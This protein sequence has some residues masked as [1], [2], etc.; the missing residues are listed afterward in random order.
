MDAPGRA[1]ILKSEAH[2][3]AHAIPLPDP[4]I[5]ALDALE[6]QGGRCRVV[7]GS[8][9]DSL[10]GLEP[11]D[12][13][14]EVYGLELRQIA[15]TLS[16]LGKTDPVGKAFAV[17]KLWTG[18]REYDFS[19]PRRESKTGA[20]HRGFE[21]EPDPSLS[22]RDAIQRRDFTLNALLYDHRANEIIDYCGGIRDL[23]ERLLRHVSPAFSED[24][25]RALRAMQLAARFKLTLD[26]D[27]A[28]MCR[29]IGP[30]F[31]TL[32]KERIW[33]EWEKWATRSRSPAHGLRAL[34]KSGWLAFFPEL[35]ALA[36]LPQDP[37][38]HP[39]GDV[40]THTLCALDALAT[41][42]NWTALPKDARAIVAFATLCH[43]LGKARSTRWTAKKGL[44][45]WISPGHE[46]ESLW[47]ASRFFE[48]I[49]APHALRERALKLV[50]NHHFLN[51]APEDGH[52]DAALRRLAKRLEP[53][54]APELGYLLKADHLGRPPLISKERST[55]IDHFLERIQELELNKEG[56]RPILLGRHLIERGLAAG[57]AFK[58]IL[59]AAYEAQLGGEI[60]DATSAR[61]WLDKELSRQARGAQ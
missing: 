41:Q 42:T 13:D 58:P 31:W 56:P 38:W 53:A 55:A 39:E 28:S 45:R 21:I 7:G 32:P 48:R 27:T 47:L 4:L 49:G 44:K 20:G 18:R 26:P 5:R 1:A 22:E 12:I 34:E 25:L 24:P 37:T 17:V 61:A 54:S 40:W 50:G 30:E 51:T 10:L 2:R 36:G 9:R 35:N 3:Q 52:R 6:S 59:Q 23:Q 8:V 15:S 57:P 29:K 16:A 43:D 19:I 60:T 33:T 11:K 14:I 46:S